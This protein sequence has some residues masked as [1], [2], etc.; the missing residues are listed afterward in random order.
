MHLFNL[1]K[2]VLTLYTVLFH[3]EGH[4]GHG[5]LCTI[6]YPDLLFSIQNPAKQGEPGT[7]QYNSLWSRVL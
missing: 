4:L 7:S 2:L 3:M 5:L 6:Y 1:R